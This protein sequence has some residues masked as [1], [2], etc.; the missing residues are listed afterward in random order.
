MSAPKR[1]DFTNEDYAHSGITIEYIKSRDV[2]HVS[3]WYDT[4]VGIEGRDIT[5]AEFERELGIPATPPREDGNG[6]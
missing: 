1:I 5:R 2:L 4:F 6:E 3:G